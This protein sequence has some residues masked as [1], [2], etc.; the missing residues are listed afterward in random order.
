MLGMLTSLNVFNAQADDDPTLTSA[1][2]SF[3]T[4]DDDKD[5]NTILT[6]SI[7]KGHDEYAKVDGI[8]GKFDDHS[9]N[10]PFGV[11]IEGTV[12]K[13]ALPGATLTLK[14]RP[15]GN[16]TWKFNCFL[17]LQFSD[18]SHQKFEWF[19][20]HLNEGRGDILHLEM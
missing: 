10:G 17:E 6:I 14:I 5:D 9:D 8:T 15:S 13:S 4:N 7:E 20:K 2:A 16:D 19:G 12:R 11:N 18:G 3:H 1:F